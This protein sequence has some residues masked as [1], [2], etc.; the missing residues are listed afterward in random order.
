MATVENVAS[1]LTDML[2]PG[3]D[4]KHGNSASYIQNRQIIS[5]YPQSANSF[6]SSGQRV[7]RIN[8]N[9]ADGQWIDP[10]SMLLYF[11]CNNKDATAQ[12]ANSVTRMEPLGQAHIWFSS[13]KILCQGQL[14]EQIDGYI[15]GCMKCSFA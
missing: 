14:V 7:I 3:L 9:S 5:I 10:A 4:F 11:R 12:S 13:M 6:S 8:L 15:I 1:S 2:I